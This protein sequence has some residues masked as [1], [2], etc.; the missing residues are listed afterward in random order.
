MHKRYTKKANK[1]D[2]EYG[3]NEKI[4]EAKRVR[5]PKKNDLWVS[6]VVVLVITVFA[7]LCLALDDA[8]TAKL[9]GQLEKAFSSF[10]G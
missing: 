7:A 1:E 9:L 3:K 5:W 2:S 10:R 6:I 8:L 4:F